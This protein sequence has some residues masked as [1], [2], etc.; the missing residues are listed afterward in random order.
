[1][2]P[3]LYEPGR[4]HVSVVGWGSQQ[5]VDVDLGEVLKIG[6]A[7]AVYSVQRM[8]V[9]M[10]EAVFDGNPITIARSQSKLTPDFDAYLVLGEMSE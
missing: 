6:D 5:S 1:M 9:P 3:N 4:A 10:A 8:D 2:R 7:Y